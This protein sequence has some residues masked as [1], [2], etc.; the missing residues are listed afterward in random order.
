M[1][2]PIQSHSLPDPLVLMQDPCNEIHLIIYLPLLEPSPFIQIC[3]PMTT[4]SKV[5]VFKPKPIAFVSIIYTSS[6][7]GLQV[8]LLSELASITETLTNLLAVS[9]FS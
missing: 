9:G 4:W 1:S 7:G 5:G 2:S 8:T 3:H 6:F